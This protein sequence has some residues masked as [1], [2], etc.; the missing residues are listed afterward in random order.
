MD[1]FNRSLELVEDPEERIQLARYNLLAG[2]KAK[3]SA[4]YTS[5]LK[6]FRFGKILLTCNSWQE[7]YKLSYDLFLELAQ[8]EYLAGNAEEAEELFDIV[9]QKAGNEVERAGVYSLKVVIYA[10]MGRYDDAVN[11]GIIAL[12]K[13]R[14]DSPSH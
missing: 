6:Y 7:A 13:L 2:R 12:G 4:A 5:A 9:L 8:A 11:T 3:A 1:H 10:K 14:S